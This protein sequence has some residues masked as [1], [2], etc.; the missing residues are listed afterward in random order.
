[1]AT[2]LSL[3]FSLIDA[4]GKLQTLAVDSARALVGSGAHCE[5]RLSAEHCPVEQLL[6][7]ARSG[8]VYAEARCLEPPA[9][10]NGVPFTQGR[11][12]PESVIQIGPCRLQVQLGEASLDPGSSGGKAKQGKGKNPVIQVLG[13]IALPMGLYSLFASPPE[14]SLLTKPVQ[15]PALF[16]HAAP[17]TCPRSSASEASIVAADERLL[18]DSKRERSPFRVEEGVLAVAHYERAAACFAR[19]GDH[20]AKQQS[21]RDMRALKKKLTRDFHVHTVRLERA[22][23]TREF[24]RART[25]IRVLL[26]YLSASAG[27]YTN[28]L[29]TLDRRIQL[30]YSGKN[31]ESP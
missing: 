15:P 20:P 19:A 29:A 13:L 1:M 27:E 22:L 18:A 25:E 17:I 11:I 9:L 26:S 2:I 8:G 24:E 31:K 4:G 12:L 7:E 10:L 14:Q 30:K 16:A 3:K 21:E 5:V 23:A 28:W 6:L